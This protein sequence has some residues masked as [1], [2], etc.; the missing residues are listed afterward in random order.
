M[1]SDSTRQRPFGTCRDYAPEPINTDSV[2][3]PGSII[4]LIETLAENAH[5]IWA[6]QRLEDGW[7][8]GPERDDKK[9]P[10]PSLIPYKKLPE[11]EQDYGRIMV[12]GTVK[13][14]LALGWKM[15]PGS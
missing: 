4:H 9:K 3:I 12:L 11:E 6:R 1:E 13:T 8:F 2:E 14:I 15:E 7:T 5:D 10:H